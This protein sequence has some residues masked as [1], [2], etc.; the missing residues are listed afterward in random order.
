M[1]SDTDV[2]NRLDGLGE[3]VCGYSQ[4]KGMCTGVAM[5]WV[6]R[7][8]VGDKNNETQPSLYP[9]MM[10][11]QDD[12]FL[13]TNGPEI[14]A[15]HNKKN[16]KRE[17]A[18][19]VIYGMARNA[20]ASDVEQNAKNHKCLSG[21]NALNTQWETA[22]KV[23]DPNQKHLARG[24]IGQWATQY[25]M[26]SPPQG[27]DKSTI[28]SYLEEVYQSAYEHDYQE[29]RKTEPIEVGV[30]KEYSEEVARMFFD[31]DAS[32]LRAR[33]KE[34][35]VVESADSLKIHTKTTAEAVGQALRNKHFT[36]GRAM[37]FG[38]LGRNIAHSL[39]LYHT[40]KGV[41]LWMDPNYGVWYLDQ[42]NV[43]TAMKY[44]FDATGKPGEAGVYQENE[45][46][47]PTGFE[48]SVW[49]LR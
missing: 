35:K 5:E 25:G 8:L 40:S 34:I 12:D 48:Y 32:N 28:A 3:R 27:V 46:G 9:K 17:H 22:A 19:K 45:K 43:V 33:F 7:L 42:P 41:Y 11:G 39:G 18:Q 23:A 13:R 15:K 4:I 29:W 36:S 6:R 44:L 37:V 16:A 47:T 31:N 14:L 49:D 24:K 20:F 38:I 21:W 30:F 10:I 1:Y 26:D 2:R